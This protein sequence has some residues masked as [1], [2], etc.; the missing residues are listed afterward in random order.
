MII[1]VFS[2]LN[3][4]MILRGGCWTRDPASP[5]SD[6][7]GTEWLFVL[8]KTGLSGVPVFVNIGKSD[9]V[10]VSWMLFHRPIVHS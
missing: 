4:S 1:E 2:N 7:F 10:A 3:D 5:W 6:L 8:G 9:G